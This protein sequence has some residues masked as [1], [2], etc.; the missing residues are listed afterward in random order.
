MAS[1]YIKNNDTVSH[2]WVGQQIQAGDYYLIPAAELPRWQHDS[3]LM[4]AI[5]NEKAV[6]ARDESGSK[7][8]IDVNDGIDFLKESHKTV[9]IQEE[10]PW[11]DT[12][13][14]YRVQSY[15]IV[16]DQ[17]Q[18]TW[19][20]YDITFPYPVSLFS[21]EWFNKVEND[22]DIVQCVAAPDTVIGA[23]TSDV[24]IDDNVIDVSETVMTYAARGTALA[25]DDGVNYCNLGEIINI[26]Y[27]NSQVTTT[28]LAD[29]NFLAS[30]PTYVK[31]SVFMM[32]HMYLTGVG[33]IDIGKDA[34]G[35][36][37]LPANTIFRIR[38][39]NNEGTTT[40][41]IFSF[42]LEYKY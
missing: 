5:A 34:V 20:D 28:Y 25:L 3:P 26:D 30:T 17:A 23:I 24:S 16:V 35:G 10:P 31:Q 8:I 32:P 36:S 21:A 41:K 11:S 7:D 4:V 18:G 6:V 1:I 29:N 12:G 33:R 13:G 9:V 27:E 42:I 38:Y 15:E 37:Y 2:I 39:Q 22:G 40:N 14:T 19:K